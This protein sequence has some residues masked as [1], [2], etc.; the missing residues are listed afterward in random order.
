MDPYLS[1]R[2]I[3]SRVYKPLSYRGVGLLEAVESS[4]YTRETYR[5]T[6]VLQNT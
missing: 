6:K 1:F 4:A 3:C 5:G 2:K